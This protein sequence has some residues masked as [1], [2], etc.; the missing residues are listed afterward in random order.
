VNV[1]QPVVDDALLAALLE[2]L[3]ALSSS[4]FF[5]GNCCAFRRRFALRHLFQPSPSA[6]SPSA[7]QP[8]TV[9]FLAIAPLRGPLRVR[10]LVRVRWPCTGRPRRWRMPR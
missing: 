8:Y 4:L 6:L 7:L 1:R 5:L 3:L 9:F 10:A 2:R